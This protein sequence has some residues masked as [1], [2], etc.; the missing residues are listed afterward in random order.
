MAFRTLDSAGDMTF[1]SGLNNY[2]H[3]NDEIS[4]DIRTNINSW[5]GDCFFATNKGIDWWNRLGSK[6]QEKL[7]E[8]DISNIILNT[9]G[10]TGIISISINVNDRT[11]K[12]EYTIST[13]FSQSFSDLVKGVV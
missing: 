7:L 9:K 11:F 12:A 10:V 3:N 13:I 4:L 6:T 5:L 8:Q 2:S 1:G